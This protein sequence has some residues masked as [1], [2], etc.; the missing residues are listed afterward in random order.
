MSFM[1]RLFSFEGRLRRRDWWLINIGLGVVNYII[2]QVIAPM[3]LGAEGRVQMT[4]GS[5]MPTYPMPLLIV[6]LV[7]AAIIF[8]PYLALSVKRTHD[9][10]QSARV[11]IG[12]ILFNTALSWA[13]IVVMS[14]TGELTL[15]WVS[16]AAGT[17]IGLYLLITL[18]FLDGT[19]GPN[20]FGPSPKGLAGQSASVANE[21]S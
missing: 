19:Q 10:D 9:R 21:F 4:P 20:R 3:V 15:F 8:W 17:I 5:F 7:M 12:L 2:T 11:N 6:M 1:D 13:G 18:G 16:A 14:L